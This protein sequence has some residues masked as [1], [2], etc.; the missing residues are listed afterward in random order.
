M[1]QT[2]QD[3][4]KITRMLD[5]RYIWIDA[6]CIIQDSH[7]DWERES[8]SMNKVYGNAYLTIAALASSKACDRFLLR[9]SE[10]EASILLSVIAEPPSNSNATPTVIKAYLRATDR[11]DQYMEEDIHSCDWITRGWTHQER[12]L[13]RRI[14]YFTKRQLY[15]SCGVDYRSENNEPAAW[16]NLP[17]RFCGTR[18]S[19]DSH[20]PYSVTQRPS[21]YDEWYQITVDYCRCKLTYN[22]DKLPAITGLANELLTAVK[23]PKEQF[24]AGLWKSDLAYGL[25]W[26]IEQ[27]W[28][29]K[30]TKEN[31][32]TPS[33]SWVSCV[34]R[35]IYVGKK[36]SATDSLERSA[37]QM[38]Q[39]VDVSVKKVGV[40]QKWRIVVK[41]KVVRTKLI[42]PESAVE[43]L[44]PSQ[45][46]KW[47]KFPAD[48]FWCGFF[49][50]VVDEGS[51]MVLG[52]GIL[53]EDP[54][55]LLAETSEGDTKREIWCFPVLP[56]VM[57]NLEETSN[58]GYDG[59][60]V[61]D[62]D[63]DEPVDWKKN[64]SGLLMEEV[65]GKDMVFRRIGAYYLFDEWTD[66]FDG[67][68]PEEITL[69]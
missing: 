8:Q 20:R 60:D 57:S 6:L 67:V 38:F 59:Y 50:D 3:A 44:K 46:E 15:F 4:V 29:I 18:F 35:I 1:P 10:F 34:G 12:Y 17:L 55:D 52:K 41:G 22:S 5:I 65:E 63:Y 48:V 21:I 64:W 36:W 37:R 23:D 33:W 49:Y 69:V 27:G 58:E 25:L 61:E 30:P 14:F 68:E 16:D 9:P 11:D 13:A 66:Y 45:E 39:L 31:F 54:I 56:H 32:T 62:E 19:L 51:G 2:L 42:L 28:R 26:I 40:I 47:E 7:D 24:L 43:K 53:D